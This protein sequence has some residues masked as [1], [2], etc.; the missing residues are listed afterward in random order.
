[1]KSMKSFIV[2]AFAVMITCSQWGHA[3]TLKQLNPS[4]WTNYTRMDFDNLTQEEKTDKLQKLFE[5]KLSFCK[6]NNTRRTLI[7][8]LDPGSFAFFSPENF[9]HERDDNFLYWALHLGKCSEVEVIFDPSVFKLTIPGYI[10][11]FFDL[12]KSFFRIETCFSYFKNF[13]EK[14]MWVSLINDY[15][16]GLNLQGPIIKGITI[17]PVGLEDGEAQLVI[18]ALDQYKYNVSEAYPENKFSSI[19]LGAVLNLDQRDLAVANLGRFPLYTDIRSLQPNNIGLSLPE[20]FPAEGGNFQAPSWRSDVN[21]PLLDTVYVDL[22]D[23]RL[24]DPI[25][26]NLEV[27][28]EPSQQDHQAP[29][30]LSN[31]LGMSMRGEPLVKGP[32]L[33]SVEKGTNVIQGKYTFFRTGTQK[34]AIGKFVSYNQIEVR[35]PY[36]SEVMRKHVKASPDTNK[37]MSVS[38]SFSTTKDIKN[39]EYYMSPTPVRWNS[40]RISNHLASKIYYV[41]STEFT[42]PERKF[43]GNWNFNNFVDFLYKSTNQHKGNPIISGFLDTTIY[44]G[45]NESL[46]PTNNIVIYDFTTIPNGHP[47]PECDWKLDN[48]THL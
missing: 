13:I 8:I 44:W 1:M 45:F 31:Y 15:S 25:Y 35:P 9:S 5:D 30:I 12:T 43:M 19:R 46:S 26:Q 18:N 7:R 2:L 40:T 39:A 48:K 24:T 17:H 16:E 36:T 20:N 4:V 11:R 38:S 29:A 42:P 27:L 3:N 14:L 47:Y 23:P 33:I 21:T 41:F 22:G 6:K 28:K 34:H 32:G 37:E 10:D